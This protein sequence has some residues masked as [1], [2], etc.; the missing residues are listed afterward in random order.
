MRNIN[1]IGLFDVE[2]RLL[3]LSETKD[4]LVRLNRMID[5]EQF[6]RVLEE[7]LR[8]EP[9]GKGGRPPFD[10]L[11]MFK[12]L[13][14]QRYYN[15]SDDQMEYQ[16]LDRMS[17]MRFL[18][19][20]ISDKVPDAKTIWH[21]REQLVKKDLMG[22]LFG[23]FLGSLERAGLVLHEGSIV[24]ASFVEVPKQRNSSDENK[25]IKAGNTPESWEKNKLAQKDVDARWS[26]KDGQTFYGYKDHVK[27]D[28]GS[29]LITGYEVT[30]ATVHDSQMLERLLD[31]TDAGQP[32]YADKAYIGKEGIVEEKNAEPR[33]N[34]RGHRNRPLTEAQKEANRLKSKVRAR[35]E[36]I[37]GFIENSMGGSFIRSIG[38]TRAKVM[39][40][41]MNLTYNLF[42]TLQL[43]KIQGITASI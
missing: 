4:P 6:R 23:Q 31:E 42:R 32:V 17:F 1:E 35:V 33:I 13:I 27:A 18:G 14:L 30:A 43:M 12:I 38:E 36:H 24:D 41:L 29:K 28:A 15:L 9:K 19:L 11:L 10:Y 2:T 5:W 7:A 16:I 3:K 37:F 40:G 21:F 8:K 22:E 25:E 34:E 26:K 39:I 20:K